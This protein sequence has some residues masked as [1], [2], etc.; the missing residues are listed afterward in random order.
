MSKIEVSKI[1]K[2][3]VVARNTH[4]Q[5]ANILSSAV[6]G[7]AT[8]G[9]DIGNG[10]YLIKIGHSGTESV[11][12]K[13]ALAPAFPQKLPGIKAL[14]NSE[15]QQVLGSLMSSVAPA[16]AIAKTPLKQASPAKS[17]VRH[18]TP[19]ANKALLTQ[20]AADENASIAHLAEQG[21]LVD[22][23][24]LAVRLKVTRQAVNK[25]AQDL[26]MFSL[27]GAGGSKLFPAFFADQTL[28]RRKIETVCK[29]LGHLPGTSKW[30]FFTTPR[31]SLGKK[32]PV[33]ALRKGKFEEVLAA[34]KSFKEA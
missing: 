21:V 5:E 18:V 14:S 28:E 34:A 33:D 3:S 9:A 25:A 17:D 29:E 6:K 20:F 15:I 19:E 8:R 12:R 32:S 23:Q 11:V 27:D 10:F 13:R 30:Q 7:I 31:L 26:R 24:L 1:A 4:A 16:K 22:S 2:Q